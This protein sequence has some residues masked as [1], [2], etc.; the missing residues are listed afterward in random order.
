MWVRD[1]DEV[2]GTV[3]GKGSEA[4]LYI[5]PSLN[6]KVTVNGTFASITGKAKAESNG[7]LV[8]EATDDAAMQDGKYANGTADKN[9]EFEIVGGGKADLTQNGG[10]VTVSGGD[11]GAV[12]VA[13]NAKLVF[14]GGS[15][16]GATQLTGSMWIVNAAQVDGVVT[17][18]GDKAALYINPALND[19]VTVK[20]VYAG[21]TGVA[22]L[23]ESGGSTATTDDRLH[24]GRSG[25]GQRNQV[26]Q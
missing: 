3:I 24:D 19:M 25:E 1:A 11:I 14:V 9:K 20:G 7:A 23:A 12:S 26:C 22:K 21:I 15:L 17:G 10:T 2:L 13:E 18:V 8:I 4:K 16:Y 6:D 5:N